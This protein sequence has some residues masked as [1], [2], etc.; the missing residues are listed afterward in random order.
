MLGARVMERIVFSFDGQLASEHRMDFYEA[1]RFQ[2]AASRLLV[3]LDQFRRSGKFTKH[4]TDHNNTRMMLSA[5]TEGSFLIE[6]IAPFLPAVAETFI[7]SPI[8]VLLSYVSDRLFKSASNED[9]KLAFETQ[10]QLIGLQGNLLDANQDNTR[11]AIQMLAHEISA[12]RQLNEQNRELYERL[13][14]ETERR[15]Y[16]Q[17]ATEQLQAIEPDQESKL[18]AMSGPLM[19]EMSVA[20]RSSASSL[21]ISSD[22]GIN[23]RRLVYVNKRMAS[24][25][26]TEVIDKESTVL[27]VK[28][29]QYNKETGWGKLRLTGLQTPLSFS[30]PGDRKAKIQRRVIS[31]MREEQTYIECKFVR[32]PEGVRTRA[33][34]LGIA[35]IEKAEGGY[36]V[37]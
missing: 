26:E 36:I 35:D 29:I 13:L 9:V 31:E 11:S 33:L 22:D 27:L 16:L 1:G 18:L 7:T 12:G 28:L 19:K 10:Q 14:A 5:Q 23:R 15:A 30:V 25:I 2:Y 20:L 17:G 4:I 34:L 37:Q 8:S 3:K 32:T 6:A 21:T 24:E